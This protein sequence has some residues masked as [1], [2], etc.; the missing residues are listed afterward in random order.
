M[1]ENAIKGQSR[2]FLC[3]ITALLKN[4]YFERIDTKTFYVPNDEMSSFCYGLLNF[5]MIKSHL[6]SL[7]DGKELQI[8]NQQNE[9]YIYV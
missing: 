5:T 3:I 6:Q 4:S 9:I 2:T 7:M 8:C 1:L